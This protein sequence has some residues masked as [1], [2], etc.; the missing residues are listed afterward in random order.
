MMIGY[1]LLC[2][3]IGYVFGLFQTS[4]IIGKLHHMDIRNVGSGNAGT[5]NTLRTFGLKAGLAALAGDVLKCLLAVTAVKLLFSSRAGDLLPLLEMYTGAG[6]ILGHNYPFYMNFRGG[7]GIASTLGMF[8]AVDWRIGLS[9]FALFL[10]ILFTTHYVSLGSICAY[11]AAFLLVTVFGA[12][13]YYGMDLRHT[14]EMDGI[15]ALLACL[16]IWKH[17]GNIQRLLNGT[18][19][20]TYLGSRH[21]QEEK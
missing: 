9:C 4:F 3:L 11:I 2:L 13:G 8:L 1:R 20:K 21:R 19:R 5:T 10:V 16:T 14:V 7:K 15:M 6:C 12:A 18:E 17:R